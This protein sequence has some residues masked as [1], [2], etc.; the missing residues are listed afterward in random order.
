M[1]WIKI[2]HEL[3]D[4]PE[5]AGIAGIL[6]IDQDAVV[7]KLIRVWSWLDQHTTDGRVTFA[8]KTFVDRLAFQPGFGDAMEKVSWLKSSARG[9]W[10]VPNFARHNGETAKSRA[11][12]AKRVAEFRHRKSDT[13]PLQPALHSRYKIV[14]SESESESESETKSLTDQKTVFPPKKILGQSAQPGK[15]D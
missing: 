8:S 1:S 11:Q 9:G 12:T 4:K 13:N 2:S 10:A 7:G 14:T 15:T 3:P 5:V 6:N